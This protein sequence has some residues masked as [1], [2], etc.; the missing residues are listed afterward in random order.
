M[1]SGD[2]GIASIDT[3]SQLITLSNIAF[4]RDAAI[5]ALPIAAG[6]PHVITYLAMAGVLAAA[7]AATARALRPRPRLVPLPEMP[8]EPVD[9]H[10]LA[11][12]RKARYFSTDG[13]N[14]RRA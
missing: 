6:F 13:V 1:R 8:E 5:F 10:P 9:E 2:V 11:W 12:S 7:L 14:L 3:K 4:R